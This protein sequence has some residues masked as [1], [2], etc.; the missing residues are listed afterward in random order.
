MVDTF[1]VFNDLCI[2]IDI[3]KEQIK[4]TERELEYWFGIRMHDPYL[5]GFPLNGIGVNKFGVASALEQAENKV[6]TINRLRERLEGLEETKAKIESL[7]VQFKGHD[8]KIAYLRYVE[9]KSL[10]EISEEIHLNYDY[11]RQI[12]SR[13]KKS[14]NSQSSHRHIENNVV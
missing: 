2:E 1:I 13:M 3:L 14:I 11:V 4:L 9:G 10:K 6:N 12:M 8:Y 5:N 7:L